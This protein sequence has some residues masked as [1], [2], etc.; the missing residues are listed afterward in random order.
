M[1]YEI[2]NIEEK[3]L[4]WPGHV[5]AV[6]KAIAEGKD[7]AHEFKSRCSDGLD[8]V[9]LIVKAADETWTLIHKGTEA[10]TAMSAVTGLTCSAT[11][12]MLLKDKYE[13]RGIVLPETIGKNAGAF[14]FILE[15]LADKGLVF[16]MSRKARCS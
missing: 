7:L 3:T 15:K 1:R 11:V 2:K 10:R 12:Q 9:V 14:E 13:G 8:M 5:A 16:E 6:K 4:R